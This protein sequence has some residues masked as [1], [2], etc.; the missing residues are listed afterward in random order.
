M[1]ALAWQTL[2]LL[3]AAYFLGATTACLL[4]RLTAR[5]SIRP[6]P[7]V[8]QAPLQREAVAVPVARPAPSPARAAL[9]REPFRRADTDRPAVKPVV[10]EPVAQ[11]PPAVPDRALDIPRP[12]P[13]SLVEA[14]R[15]AAE[16]ARRSAPPLTAVTPPPPASAPVRASDSLPTSTAAA[17]VAAASAAMLERARVARETEPGEAKRVLP[18][19]M[20][21]VAGGGTPQTVQVP[22]AKR[23]PAPVVAPVAAPAPRGGDDL[24]RIR[25]IDSAL[26]GRL[27]D[28]GVNR[29]EQIAGWKRDDV[30]RVATALGLGHRI[31]RENWIEQAAILAKGTTT[32]FVSRH[33]R[34]E[35][36]TTEK[37]GAPAETPSARPVV[38]TASPVAPPHREQVREAPVETEDKSAPAPSPAVIA[39]SL[40]ALEVARR[41]KPAGTGIPEAVAPAASSPDVASRAAFAAEQPAAAPVHKPHDKLQRIRGVS[42]EVETLLNAGGVVRY[43]DIAGWSPADVRKY[44]DALGVKGRI[45]RENWIEQALILSKGGETEFSRQLDQGKADES[46]EV[47]PSGPAMRPARLADAIRRNRDPAAGGVAGIKA[48]LANF[49]SVRSEAYRTPPAAPGETGRGGG[50]V[51][52]SATPDDLKRIRGVGVLI[53]RRLHALGVT[54]YEQVA[55]WTPEEIARVSEQLDFKG[56]IERENWVEQARILSAGGQTDFSR[57]VDRGEVET[58][59]PKT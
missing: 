54:S 45:E 27:R 49:R 34:G 33:E 53:E 2:L 40:A 38:R 12:R 55:N 3:L 17:A 8:E 14:A 47:A 51:V 7:L 20:P 31:E 18:V 29:Y 24:R 57:R 6:G 42:A 13:E 50:K 9:T 4:R 37:T 1:T 44:N 56:R 25:A 30:V 22:V 10:E 32:H 19:P 11:A 46:S 28:M 23:D 15:A 39:A 36:A 16:A 52:R 5:P 58:S 21:S 59:K 43:S 48:D 35:L 26:E 41:Q